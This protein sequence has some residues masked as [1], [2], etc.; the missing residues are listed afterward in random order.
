MTRSRFAPVVLLL[1]GL[2]AAWPGGRSAARETAPGRAVIFFLGDGMG[3]P[4]VTAARIHR[5]A[6]E[7]LPRTASARLAVDAAPRGALVHTGSADAM[8]TDSAAAMTAL[9]CGRKTLNGAISV[10]PGPGGRTDTLTTLLEIA[11]SRGLSTGVVTTTRVTHATPAACYAHVLD[12]GEEETIAAAAVPG[13]G[14]P[15]LGDGMEVI[16]GGGRLAWLPEGTEEG[17]RTDGRN[18]VREM[19]T[20]GYRV[21]RDTG[22]LRRA[23]ADGARRLLG[24]FSNSHMAYEADRDTTDGGQPSLAEM[25]RAAITV[26]RRNPA[27][28]FLMVEGGRIDHALHENNGYRAVTDML[29]FDAAVAEARRLAGDDALILVTAD[30]DHTMTLTG[31]A[32]AAADVFTQGGKDMNGVPYTAILFGTGPTA[33]GPYPDTLDFSHGPDPD[34]RERA[35]IPLSYEDHGAVDVPLYAFGPERLLAGI[36]GSMDNTEVFGVLRAALEER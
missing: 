8:V 36:H 12:R 14:N 35:A 5:G 22:D 26:L 20:A 33:A 6:L 27:G 17:R 29:A 31:E 25:T 10:V 28:Y 30:H 2:L 21:A 15:R 23:E 16:L 32:D 3:V 9:V 13:R 7:G 24:L 19:E 4:V 34:F 11:E 18:L 1:A